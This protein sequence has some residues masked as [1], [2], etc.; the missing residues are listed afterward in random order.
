M[1]NPSDNDCYLDLK[2]LSAYSNLGVSTLRYHIKQN[3][4]PCFQIPGKMDK[5]GKILVL[6]SEFDEWLEQFRL[7]GHLNINAVADEVVS[8]IMAESDR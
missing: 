4:L 5:G 8:R 3:R 6:R 7:N 2:G 1:D